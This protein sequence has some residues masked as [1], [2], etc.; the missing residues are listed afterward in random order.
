MLWARWQP[1]C[2]VDV[3]CVSLC[4]NCM[5]VLFGRIMY[6]TQ[7]RY[8]RSKLFEFTGHACTLLSL[9]WPYESFL[10][11]LHGP[12]LTNGKTQDCIPQGFLILLYFCEGLRILIQYTLLQERA[13]G[14]SRAA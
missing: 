7:P 9:E 8:L 13:Y 11:K 12:P 4:M 1:V 2:V 10:H 14:Q 6:R 5:H 3:F